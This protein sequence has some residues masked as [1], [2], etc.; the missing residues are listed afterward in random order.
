MCGGNLNQMQ[1][2]A[3]FSR[4]EDAYLFRSFLVSE[5]LD[6]YVFDEYVPQLFWYYTQAVGGVRVVVSE[7]DFEAAKKLYQEYAKSI[8]EAPLMEPVRAWPLVA[9][10]S[11]V[12][13]PLPM[14]IL[15]RKRAGN[16]QETGRKRAGNGQDLRA[17]G[18]GDR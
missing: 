12:C 4:G 17:I 9:L 5:G 14:I 16:G 8:S 7:D 3:T 6:A 2:V 18:R 15:G 13:S 10:L 11:L 1:T